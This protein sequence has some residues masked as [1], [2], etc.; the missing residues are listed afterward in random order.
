MWSQTRLKKPV[1][2]G[3][4]SRKSQRGQGLKS[5]SAWFYMNPCRPSGTGSFVVNIIY[6]VSTPRYVRIERSRAIV[7]IAEF[8][9]RYSRLR[10]PAVITAELNCAAASCRSMNSSSGNRK[11]GFTWGLLRRPVER[12]ALGSG[13]LY[14][15][16]S[17]PLQ[18]FLGSPASAWCSCP[19][20][21]RLPAHSL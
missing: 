16:I 17:P 8:E 1:V 5:V 13:G 21:S 10:P 2:R 14:R 3:R 11:A 12:L 7:S 15:P 4:E 9:V 6:I 20:A 18:L 19:R